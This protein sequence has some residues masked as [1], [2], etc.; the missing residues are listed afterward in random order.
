MAEG[1]P[2]SQICMLSNFMMM[3]YTAAM[4]QP[5]GEQRATHQCGEVGRAMESPGTPNRGY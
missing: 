1:L 3:C 2:C 4:S 5:E